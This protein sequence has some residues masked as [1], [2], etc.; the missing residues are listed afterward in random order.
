MSEPPLLEIRSVTKRYAGRPAAAL[1][2]FSLVIP[3][4][5]ATITT[6]AG[7]SGSGKT[8]LADAVLG[9]VSPTSG[10]ILFRGRD[11][12]HLRRRERFEYRRSVQ[13]IFQDPYAAYN[14]FYPVRHALQ[15]VIGRF[16]L[17]SSR[18]QARELMNEALELVGLR[19]DEVLDKHPH[20]LS[21]GQR[22]RVMF[23]RAHLVRPR[24][25]V[26]DEPV[27]MIDAS[28]RATIIDIMLKM[29]DEDGTSF[30]YI[31]H[32]LS[33]AYQVG[34]D[35]VILYAGRVAESGEVTTVLEQP[36]HPYVQLLIDSVPIPDPR[37]R[38]EGRIS[39]PADGGPEQAAG[40]LYAARCPHRMDRCS[41]EAP[42]QY[43]T[44]AGHRAACY[45][46]EP[47]DAQRPAGTPAGT[48]A[49]TPTT[50]AH[51]GNLPQ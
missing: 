35:I 29:R 21:G 38:W 12:A 16:G 37:R 20:Q 32:D 49:E 51:G 10:S 41:E 43:E 5:P 33:T 27:S 30:L 17:A 8:T 4:S 11:I 22:Q 19:G 39:L 47:A 7:E 28:L 14:P 13:A 9:F 15:Q 6:I 1:D 50:I 24:L 26:A 36:K 45:L 46:Y 44:G 40:C 42:A 3:G 18:S 25:I 23:A 31:T 2:Q 48:P 34:N